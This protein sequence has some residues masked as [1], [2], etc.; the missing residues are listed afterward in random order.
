MIHHVKSRIA[1]FLT[2][3]SALLALYASLRGILNQDLY[4]EVAEAGTISSFLVTGSLAQDIILLPTAL[5]LLF[6]T[7]RFLWK[8]SLKILILNLGLISFIFY[9]YGLY[10][11]QGQ[12]TDLYVMYLAIFGLSLYTIIYGLLAIRWDETSSTTLSK[13]LRASLAAFLLLIPL[14]LIPVWLALIF[15][16]IITHTPSDTYAVFILDLCV[17]FPALVIIAWL[18]FANRP[19]GNILGGL[20]IIKAFTICLSVAFGEWFQGFTGDQPINTGMLAIFLPLTLVSLAMVIW[21][22]NQLKITS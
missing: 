12:Y 13:P 14:V 17:V 3:L 21:Y 8:P 4:T 7:I 10:V 1:A 6:L 22:F 15:P 11:I 5:L 16:D 19:A 9:G 2:G 20:A 18:L